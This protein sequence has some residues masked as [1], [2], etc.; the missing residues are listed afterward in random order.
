MIFETPIQSEGLCKLIKGSDN[1]RDW[2]IRKHY[3][4]F[5][6]TF[7]MFH[8]FLRIKE[9]HEEL[10]KFETDNWPEKKDILEHCDLIKWH[11]IINKYKIKDIGSLDRALAFYHCTTPYNDNDSYEKLLSALKDEMLIPPQV[12]N[13]PEILENKLLEYLSKGGIDNLFCYS[14]IDDVEQNFSVDELIKADGLTYHV[15]LENK[16]K[17]I[18]I[19]QDFDQRFSYIFGKQDFVEKLVINLDLEGFYCDD[20]IIEAWS[21]IPEIHKKMRWRTEE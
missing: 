18:L 11:E 15:R 13:F 20:K 2:P 5:E 9:G 21:L 10:I 4:G 16:E 6:S 3:P 1:P 14:D 12:D 7:L 17:H 8:P 19:V